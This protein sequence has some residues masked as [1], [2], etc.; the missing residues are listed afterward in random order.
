MDEPINFCETRYQWLSPF[1]ANRIEIWGEV[2]STIEHA[3]QSSRVKPGPERDRITN[4]TSPYVAWEEGQKCKE[5]PEV[6]VEG[7]DKLAT[8]EEIYRAAL[9]QHPHLR[10]ILK[11]TGDRPLIKT[12]ESDYFWGLGKDGTGENHMS[13]LLMKLRSELQ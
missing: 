7:F 11:E 6:L 5:H 10:E 3:Y 1:A 8:M 2:F 12:V 9:D 4:A 13:K